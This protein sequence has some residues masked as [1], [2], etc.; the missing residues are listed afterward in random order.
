MTFTFMSPWQHE[1]RDVDVVVDP[2]GGD[3]M[4][5]SWSVLRPGGILVAI[6]E[7]PP[8]GHGGRDDV[9]GPA[10]PQPPRQSRDHRRVIRRARAAGARR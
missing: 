6:A 10:A 5:R 7:E 9:R 8:E 2:V 4:A 3:T 1:V